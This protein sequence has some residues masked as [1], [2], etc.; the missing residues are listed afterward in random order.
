MLGTQRPPHCCSSELTAPQGKE[1]RQRASF[2]DRQQVLQAT[3]WF[4]TTGK[5]ELHALVTQ[6]RTRQGTEPTVVSGSKSCRPDRGSPV[7]PQQPWAGT[8]PQDASPAAASEACCC[9][10][11]RSQPSTCRQAAAVVSARDAEPAP[12]RL[13]SGLQAGHH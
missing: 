13:V 6:Q 9:S 3:T 12:A 4:Q 7:R 1:A 11:C 10:C 2:A 5:P 8:R